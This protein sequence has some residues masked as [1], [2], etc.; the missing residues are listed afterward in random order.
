MI[1]KDHGICIRKTDYTDTSQILTFFC[2]EN[3]KIAGIAK[4]A[5]RSKS[6]FGGAI[7]I[8]SYGELIFSDTGGQ[9]A[10]LREFE[11][12]PRF[13]GLR[14]SL[15]AM[16]CAM[17]AAELIN[18]FSQDSDQS[19]EFF[20][21]FAEL[22]DKLQT[23]NDKTSSISALINFQLLLLDLSGI[24]IVLDRCCNCGMSKY[25]GPYLSAQA[26]GFICNDCQAGFIDKVRL[27]PAAVQ[28]LAQIN[29]PAEPQV[30][31][32]IQKALIYYFSQIMHKQPKMSKALIQIL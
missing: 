10:S 24:G 11:P 29:T 15:T 30:L 25:L 14:R 17:F 13:I 32:E 27:S 21:I 20:D 8:L 26:N 23:S 16:N 18:H 2:R 4:G 7:D 19:T 6:K 5:K 28:K 1:T 12:H 9:L 22:L 31:A 3:G